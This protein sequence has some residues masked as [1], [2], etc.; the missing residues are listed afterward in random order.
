MGGDIL[1]NKKTLLVLKTLETASPEDL[2]S[3]QTWMQ[4]GA[5]NPGQK[6]EAVR[7]IFDRNDIPR[8][9]AQE[10]QHYQDEAFQHL[11]AM[12]AAAERKILLRKM[13]EDL[14]ER[15]S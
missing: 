14:L 7:N 15:E 1:Q 4:T 2:Q 12:Q 5:E 11:D 3:L 8:L 6:I 9:M 13:M 10:K